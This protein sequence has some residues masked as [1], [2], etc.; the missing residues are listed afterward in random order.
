MIKQH[1]QII[2]YNVGK[3]WVPFAPHW[4]VQSSSFPNH[5][6]ILI[7]FFHGL[8]D[9]VK[10]IITHLSNSVV[11]ANNV[12]KL[13]VLLSKKHVTTSVASIRPVS[14]EHEARIDHED[15]KLF[16][17]SNKPFLFVIPGWHIPFVILVTE[18]NFKVLI[19][20]TVMVTTN[21]VNRHVC[22]ILTI[23]DIHHGFKFPW[24]RVVGVQGVQVVANSHEK[25]TVILRTRFSISLKFINGIKDSV[26]IVH[27]CDPAIITD[28]VITKSVF[29]IRSFDGLTHENSECSQ[30]SKG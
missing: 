8:V 18:I 17:I 29:I 16:A 23:K 14:A 30:D 20:V 6:F 22:N 10:L 7:P 5:I 25:F 13:H 26:S 28:D 19:E 24:L 27:V 4:V 9:P 1:R 21:G 12:T 2:S 3:I 11:G 15:A